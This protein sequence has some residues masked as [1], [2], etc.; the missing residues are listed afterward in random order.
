M[1]IKLSHSRQMSRLR[2]DGVVDISVA[3]ELKAA[4]L[5]AI[6]V[7]KN[8]CVSAE[9]VTELDLTAYQ[10]LWIAARQARN[11]GVSFA[12]TGPIPLPAE[13]ALAD[14]GLGANALIA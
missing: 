10:M 5:K 9:A 4:L 2:L 1:G 14:L 7:Q 6:A 13:A 8:I 3:A 11:S 12:F